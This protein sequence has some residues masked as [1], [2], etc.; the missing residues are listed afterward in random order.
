MPLIMSYLT[1]P[2]A[3]STGAVAQAAA[4]VGEVEFTGADLAVMREQLFV[5]D[6]SLGVGGARTGQC[7][8]V[9]RQ[10]GQGESFCLGEARVVPE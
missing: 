9:V 10:G 4:E 2:S 7:F 6:F 5:G 8:L 1:E 3:S